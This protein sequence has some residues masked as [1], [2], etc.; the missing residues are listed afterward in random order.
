MLKKI[1]GILV[2]LILVF[3]VTACDADDGGGAADI[4]NAPDAN[5][6]DAGNGETLE[7]DAR[8]ASIL[9]EDMDFGGRDFR[10]A[11]PVVERIYHQ[12]VAEEITGEPINDALFERNSRI[13]ERHNVNIIHVEHAAPHSVVSNTVLAGD[14]AFE[15]LI[16]NKRYTGNL[17]AQGRVLDL[18]Q[19][20]YISDSMAAGNP[21]WD[22]NLQ[23][24]LAIFNQLFMQ[25]GDLLM[26]DKLRVAVM[27]FNKDLFTALGLD[28]PY[29]HVY[30]GTWT[31]DTLQQLTRGIN[32]DLTGD[33][34]M[35]QHDQWGMMAE[36][37]TSNHFFAA[38]GNRMVTLD[39]DGMPQIT[40]GEPRTINSILR[41]LELTTDSEA[42]FHANDIHGADNIWY[43]ASAY[44]QENR[45][46]IRSSLMEPVVRDLRAMPTDFGLLPFAKF[47][48]YQENYYTWVQWDGWAVSIPAL[49]DPEFA[50][51][52]TEAINY[53]SGDTLM[54]AFVDLALTS[55]VLRDDDSESMLHIIWDNRVYDIGNIFGIG[56]LPD[57]L[58]DMTSSRTTDFVSRFE[59]AY[60]AAEAALERFLA[61]YD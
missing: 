43:Q 19:I 5:Q 58:N 47:D 40:M 3:A 38:A 55:Q 21:W 20:P 54:K 13:E 16:S 39:N 45:F 25:A 53:E 59:R 29:Q 42:M 52:V 35:G 11:M 30:D 51:F 14:N 17:G 9:S 32:T 8:P 33:G 57:I 60:G 18:F 36:H 46:A 28:F 49:A 31:L 50:G 1:A 6:V 27:Y 10:V 37:A 15:M 7:A 4:T 12:F 23:D 24:E 26:F 48:E 56:T 44:F 22:Q 34:T 41:I 2:I 61:T